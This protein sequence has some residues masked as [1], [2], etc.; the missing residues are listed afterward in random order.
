MAEDDACSR[1]QRALAQVVEEECGDL[2]LSVTPNEFPDY[3]PEVGEEY[4]SLLEPGKIVQVNEVEDD[5]VAYEVVETPPETNLNE[6]PRDMITSAELRSLFEMTHEPLDDEGESAD[7][8][9]NPTP[10]VGDWDTSTYQNFTSDCMKAGH[11]MEACA[12]WWGDVKDGD[13]TAIPDGNGE[14]DIIVVKEGSEASEKITDALAHAIADQDVGIAEVDTDE[15]QE[16]LEAL[17]D[18]PPIP[19]HVTTDDNGDYEHGDLKDLIERHV[20]V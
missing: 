4:R 19:F 16:I 5:Y 12:E 8:D 1:A 9:A 17:P 11:S 2:E 6:L 10:D 3:D 14:L 7:V 20:S 15:G 18:A 13:A